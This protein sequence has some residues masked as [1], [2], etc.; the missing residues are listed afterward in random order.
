MKRLLGLAVMGAA[1]WM[2][3]QTDK[4][5]AGY[6]SQTASPAR[7]AQNPNLAAGEGGL[8]VE[9]TVVADTQDSLII[10][11]PEGLQRSLRIQ[12]DTVYRMG[13]DGELTAREYLA[14]GAVVRASFDYNNK[15]RVAQEVIILDTVS[16]SEPNAWPEDPSPYRRDP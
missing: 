4:A 12:E 3:C 5:V 2:G 1:C 11:D 9:G 13:E 14:P 15:E 6:S 10:E 16:S 7:I 8:L